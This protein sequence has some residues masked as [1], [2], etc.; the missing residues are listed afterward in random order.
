[1][2]NFFKNFTRISLLALFAAVCTSCIKNT[3]ANTFIIANGTN[4][5][6]LNP[7]NIKT[8]A[9]ER[10]YRA[11]FEGLVSS[12]AVT[13]DASPAL[14]ESWQYSKN[15]RSI[16][17]KLRPAKWSDGKAIT[18]Q[19]VA[20]SWFYIMDNCKN[21]EKLH[22]LA[23]MIS[24]A[25]AYI[26]KKITREDVGLKVLDD[27][28]LRIEFS[29]PKA[30]AVQLMYNSAFTVLPMH[31]IKDKPD[32]WA[33][34]SNIVTNGP[35]KVHSLASDGTLTLLANNKYWN[36]NAVSLSR[37]VFLKKGASNETFKDFNNGKISWIPDI[38]FEK[39]ETVK[40]NA[41]FLSSPKACVHYY[42]LNVNHKLLCNPKVRQ[43]FSLA[44]DRTALVE[45]I[46]EGNGEPAASIVPARTGWKLVQTPEYDVAKAKQLLKES[47]F[48]KNNTD[49]IILAYNEENELYKRT[50][51]FIADEL[52]KNLGVNITLQSLSWN[53]FV[54][55]RRA[56]G[57]D[58]ARAG[59]Q[60]SSNDP[61]SFLLQFVSTDKENCG[62]YN[63]P[64]FD[65]LLR[66]ANRSLVN[67]DRLAVL[68][69]AE[70]IAVVEDT[71][72]LPL[73]FEKSYQLIN[74]SIWLG[75]HENPADI[76]TYT[77]IK[78]K[79]IEFSK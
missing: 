11:I 69:Q 64:I 28:T 30:N 6:V 58:M 16:T 13:G 59:W 44:I 66:T 53:D 51:L 50:A 5:P 26:N 22:L 40:D 63:N 68:R 75:W 42:Y 73:Y 24:G 70:T 14:A 1:M 25:Q 49:E 17:F 76:H 77:S 29:S 31:I 20:D 71:A 23:E 10:I 38:P 39:I 56:N 34:A 33:T 18:A 72:V 9:D 47:D 45:K 46:L 19:T 48:A 57:F 12:D 78:L 4:E 35:F 41:Y 65:A 67:A 36:K 2:K 52:K 37:I 21:Q 54:N 74:T 43:A 15:C 7:V 61:T 79:D 62:R 32:S 8:N 27:R 60:T 55:K 3:N